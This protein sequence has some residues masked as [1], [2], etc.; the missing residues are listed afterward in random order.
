MLR[1]HATIFFSR[2]VRS[3]T[4][5][6]FK[7]SEAFY[8]VQ[9]N[10]ACFVIIGLLLFKINQ[11]I[12]RQTSTIVL[13]SLIIVLMSYFFTDSMWVL[14]EFG[15]IPRS[16]EIMYLSTIVPYILIVCSS[17]F[18]YVYCEM[19]Q[20]NSLV[21]TSKGR[22][23]VAI[24]VLIAII[25]II[26]AVFSGV[27]F[28]F[29]DQ[30]RIQYGPLYGILV[31]IPVVYMLIAAGKAFYRAFNEDKYYDHE[32]YLVIGIFPMLPL[33]TGVLQTVFIYVPILCYG[34]TISVLLVYLTAM[35]NLISMDSLTQVN[36]R[37]QMQRYLLK[38]MHTQ[39]PGLSLYLMIVDVDHFK[40]IN[41]RYGHIEGDKALIRVATAMKEACQAHRNRFFVS[42]FGGDEFIVIAEAE[43]KGEIN[44]L[45]EKI[46]ANVK[47]LN[48][49]AGAPYNLSVCVG[50]AEFD[51]SAP[52]PIPSLI[53][54][55]D[56]DLYHMKHNRT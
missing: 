53:A 41:D 16:E 13:R 35:E 17:Y 32:L 46:R 49:K 44:W 24:P 40:E 11:G 1:F 54:R 30:N 14:L 56:T 12:D 8:Y 39:T 5:W 29:D 26:S 19:I 45:S 37:N 3:V 33:V 7:V 28:Y 55:A 42:R 21:M 20:K 36:N 10:L 47:M 31:C 15:I 43:Y 38:K 4:F 23:L 18:W 48:E 52:V 50:I 9:A 2:P 34:A 6:G 27:V 25:M 22:L 51:Y